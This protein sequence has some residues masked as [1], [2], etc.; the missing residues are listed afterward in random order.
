MIRLENISYSYHKSREILD[1][2]SL[3]IANGTVCGLLGR[4]GVGKSTF[5][6]ILAG[7]LR[8]KMGWVKCND[9]IPSERKVEFL[10]D[11]FLVPEDFFLPEVELTEY[12]KWTAPFYPKYS[13]SDMEKYLRMFD[14]E[15]SVHL[16]QLSMGQKKKV[17]LSFAMACNTSVLLL[18]EPTNGLDI[19]SKRMFRQLVASCM[20]DDKIM[21]ISTHQVYD[22][23]K[24]LDHVV[25]MDNKKILINEDVMSISMKLRFNFTTDK[26]RIENALIALP[27]P[28]GANIVEYVERPDEETELNLETLFELT[29]SNPEL[30]TR[31]FQTN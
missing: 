30:I 12:I 28:G 29:Q 20:T 25:I 7:L 26:D 6:Y 3:E 19:T 4:N 10:N 5:L 1:Y 8:P 21:I 15:S 31:I 18:D 16:G 13:Q 11:I 23:E 2:L 24:I 17:F 27:A 14:L 22:V 9:F